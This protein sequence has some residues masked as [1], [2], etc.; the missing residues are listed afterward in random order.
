L[1]LKKL[2]VRRIRHILSRLSGFENETYSP[3][4]IF[5]HHKKAIITLSGPGDRLTA[6][7]PLHLSL[8]NAT[9]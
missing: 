7:T 3:A 1:R 4:R 9:T 8:L 2:G 6:E 5:P